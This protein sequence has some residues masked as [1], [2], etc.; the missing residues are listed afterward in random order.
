MGND[1][2]T[3]RKPGLGYRCLAGVVAV[4]MALSCINGPMVAA[5]AMQTEASAIRLSETVTAVLEKDGVLV[6]SGTGATD[7]FA[8]GED[9]PLHEIRD[10]ILEVKI[11]EGITGLGDYL[12]YNCR[13]LGGTL[14]LSETVIFIGDY[15]FSGG[16]KDLAP[17]FTH[18]INEFVPVESIPETTQA[19]ET[20][21]PVETAEETEP[22]LS[23][24]ATEETEPVLSTQAAEETEPALSTQAAEETEPVLSTQ[25]AEE[26]EP[27]PSAQA[28]EES[29]TQPSTQTTEEQEI[30]VPT[31]S[32]ESFTPTEGLLTTALAAVLDTLA[33]EA[34]AEETG[35]EPKWL[36]SQKVG[37]EIFHPGQIGIVEADEENES[38]LRAARAAGYGKLLGSRD[39]VF[40]MW[41]AEDALLERTLS[42]PLTDQGVILPDYAE[43]GLP[44]LPEGVTCGGWVDAESNYYGLHS[45]APE[46]VDVLNP[47]L[48]ND[49]NLAAGDTYVFDISQADVRIGQNLNGYYIEK[50]GVSCSPTHHGGTRKATDRIIIRGTTT[51]NQILLD[52][53]ANLTVPIILDGVNIDLTNATKYNKY[54]AVD[55]PKAAIEVVATGSTQ[56]SGGTVII[57]LANGKKNVV[58]SGPGRAGIEKSSK[59]TEG[60]A[61]QARWNTLVVGC[62]AGIA[63]LN[64]NYTARTL[65]HVCNAT[66]GTLEA[67]GGDSSLNSSSPYLCGAGIGTHSAGL[68]KDG[69]QDEN[70]IN[71]LRNL[72]IAGGNITAVGGKG[73][74]PRDVGGAGIGTGSSE[75]TTVT[76]GIVSNL[77]ILC[78]NITAKGGAGPAAC[79]GG[80]YRSGY[81]SLTIYGGDID[82]TQRNGSDNGGIR[83]TGIGGGGGGNN[84][85]SPAGATVAIYGGTIRA[86]SQHGAAIGAGG[87]GNQSD[88][89]A[90]PASVS[91]YGGHITANTIEGGYGAAIGTGGPLGNGNSAKATIRIEGGTVIASSVSGAD[92]GGGG[93]GSTLTTSTSGSADV[94]I[95]GGE[96]TALSG[97]I[98]GGRA[99][100]CAGGAATVK[101]QGGTIKASLIGGGNSKTGPGG[102]AEVTITGGDLE[103]AAIGGGTSEQ[104]NGGKAKVTID[105]GAVNADSFGGGNAPEG[106]GGEAEV[107]ITGGDLEV[108]AIGGGASQKKTGGKAKVT[109]SGGTVNADSFGGGTSVEGVGG[110]AEVT[111]TG[112]SI[113]VGAIGGGYSERNIG[114]KATVTIDGG[115]MQSETIGGGNSLEGAGGE[116]DVKVSNGTIVAAI[117]GGGKSDATDRYGSAEVIITGG[118]LNSGISQ[119]PINSSGQF[120]QQTTLTAFDGK[121]QMP[122]KQVTDIEVTAGG[123]PYAYNVSR[124]VWTDELGLLYFWLP[125]DSLVEKGTVADQILKATI[126]GA[127]EYI[128]TNNTTVL[129]NTVRFPYDDYYTLYADMDDD[130]NLHNPFTRSRIAT[131]DRMFTVYVKVKDGWDLTTAYYG[132]GSTQMLPMTE[133]TEDLGNG[134]YKLEWVVCANT[135]VLMPLR[136]TAT[137]ENRLA[138]DLYLYSVVING[139]EN[140]AHAIQLGGY[141]LSDYTGSYLLTSGKT[142]TANHLT[143]NADTQLYIDS[144]TVQS[145]GSAIRIHEGAALKA[146]V[147]DTDN[148][149]AA[150]DTAVL[151]DEGCTLDLTISPGDS[152][153]LHSDGDSAIGGSGTTVITRTGGNLQLEPGGSKKQI[154]GMK[155]AYHGLPTAQ[156]VPYS[157]HPVYGMLVG[158]HNGTELL[159]TSSLGSAS[160]SFT[161]CVVAYILPTD[162]EEPK[163]TISGGGLQVAIPGGTDPAFVYRDGAALEYTKSGA[164]LTV[165]PEKSSGVIEIVFAKSGE[166]SCLAKD[167]EKEYDGEGYAFDLQVYTPEVY[168]VSYT[169][170]KGNELYREEDT[171]LPV[172]VDAGVYTISWRITAEDYA[173]KTGTNTVTIH[174]AQN[175]WLNSLIC[176]TIEIGGTPHP[177]AM[178]RFQPEAGPVYRYYKNVTDT[179]PI[180]LDTNVPGMYWAEAYV[181]E[182]EN[183]TSLISDPKVHFQITMEFVTAAPGRI[184]EKQ[185][186]VAP[187]T[188]AEIPANGAAT[189]YYGIKYHNTG[190]PLTFRFSKALPKGTTLTLM[191]LCDEHPTNLAFYYLNVEADGMTSVA[192]NDF[193]VMGTNE[194]KNFVEPMGEDMEVVEYQLCINFPESATDTSSL[195]VQLMYS[196]NRQ[197]GETVTILRSAAAAPAHGTVK[198]T[199]KDAQI[200]GTLSADIAVTSN[201]T[202]NLLAITLL[203]KDGTPVD[204]PAE[205]GSSVTLDGAHPNTVRRNHATFA[206]S[207]NKTYNLRITG[208]WEGQYR[209]KAAVYNASADLDYLMGDKVAEVSETFDVRPFV[210][211]AVT[212]EPDEE[213]RTFGPEGGTVVFTATAS[214]SGEISLSWQKKSGGS[215]TTSSVMR[216]ET[217]EENKVLFTAEIPANTEPG[218]YRWLFEYAGGQYAYHVIVS[219]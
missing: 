9:H 33:V 159:D 8:P 203:D 128:L 19:Q 32:S 113:E 105:K 85:G 148:S 82:A 179:E 30:M 132:E 171:T 214:G 102:E 104:N 41:D 59:R 1:C 213:R 163:H 166:I 150:R 69:Q 17:K 197:L 137:E 89:S 53:N 37:E 81:V 45:Y 77:N 194:K 189:I 129:F 52:S 146:A 118:S 191:D 38:F 181:P 160:G 2:Q 196:E 60:N 170:T 190:L 84:T 27:A 140:G 187:V 145:S 135:D 93:T 61:D 35:S 96:I 4:L 205:L 5:V 20:E 11:E 26:T 70:D 71:D 101:I 36:T 121:N 143:V 115:V 185:N 151:V 24:Q 34:A 172:L 116:A 206:I 186:S 180:D 110:E 58:K 66:C 169:V 3:K 106:I 80:G 12:F 200:G 15:A 48:A 103:V 158:Y 149:L 97:G 193:C 133:Y 168:T 122:K 83:G 56:Q 109:V 114:G 123:Q 120:L 209:V 130:G 25:A 174:K 49:L 215:Y 42:L 144:L 112:G 202:D 182:T 173:V 175:E 51:K 162:V 7:D 218:T 201:K 6:L 219:P 108:T 13:N 21:A 178:A 43:T 92:I 31:E 75:A 126:L 198:L 177:S 136:N 131:N 76:G 29:E 142:P 156:Q 164:N 107:I 57:E 127:N 207:G 208:L 78:G 111:I 152:L 211:A 46:T 117:I 47:D 155:L 216:G 167:Y 98:G 188:T 199:Q 28:T 212:A 14:R 23:T 125:E 40:S 176:S 192:S 67:W 44:E 10:E 88:A 73:I 119:M 72:I 65:N 74:N 68:N 91:I 50:N 62:T 141:N 79:I 139:Q 153:R 87:A 147:S 86:T 183:Y 157:F 99:N 165:S 124:D 90:Q 95:T 217:D 55:E 138:L 94:T 161:S 204:Y 210:R 134:I 154:T 22:V 16:S 39:V 184:L 64:G 100:A 63:E 18:I 54:T 195:S